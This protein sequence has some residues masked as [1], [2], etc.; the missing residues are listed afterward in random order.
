V[1]LG[2]GMLQVTRHPDRQQIRFEVEELVAALSPS[3][4]LEPLGVRPAAP[5]H[6]T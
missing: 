6:D 5:A 4:A 1:K 3:R 2:A